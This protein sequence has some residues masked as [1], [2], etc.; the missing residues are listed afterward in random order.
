MGRILTGTYRPSRQTLMISH[1]TSANRRKPKLN[2]YFIRT[3]TQSLVFSK[4]MY[5]CPWLRH[6]PMAMFR[7]KYQSRNVHSA[8]LEYKSAV[9]LILSDYS[10][11]G[12]CIHS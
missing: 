5:D 8:K 9:D 2:G 11:N 1:A 7:N 10:V 4:E 12:T 3:E 6:I